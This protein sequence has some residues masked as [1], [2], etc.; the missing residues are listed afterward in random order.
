[1][2]GRTDL[3]AKHTKF[4]ALISLTLR[5]LRAFMVKQSLSPSSQNSL[6]Q[7]AASR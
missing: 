5:V 6:S 7:Y 4:G 1:M 3:P 2:M